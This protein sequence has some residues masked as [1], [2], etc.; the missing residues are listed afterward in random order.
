MPVLVP[1]PF[2]N[3][4]EAWPDWLK[5]LVVAVI[6]PAIIGLWQFFKS[7]GWK[8]WVN[9]SDAEAAHE[10]VTEDKMLDYQQKI[11]LQR[12]DYLSEMLGDAWEFMK[13]EVVKRL[14]NADNQRAQQT[15]E[16]GEKMTQNDLTLKLFKGVL[17]GHGRNVAELTDKIE[18]LERRINRIFEGRVKEDEE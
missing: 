7:D 2:D 3:S 17:D 1:P 12:D 4:P 16:L 5:W 10:R 9:R 13:G 14:D 15:K 11:N 18:R 6:G 8:W